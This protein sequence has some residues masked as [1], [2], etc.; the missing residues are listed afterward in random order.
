MATEPF[1]PA[2]NSLRLFVKLTP[3]AGADRL[4][5]PEKTTDGRLRLKV[6][7][8]APPD[9]GKANAALIALLAKRL[10]LAKS[11]LR[12]ASGATHRDKTVIIDG[13]P[14]ELMARLRTALRNL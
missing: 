1:E 11:R 4:A 6:A 7:V 14:A 5:R 13:D 8:T 10:G 3:K 9:K 12:I 2:E